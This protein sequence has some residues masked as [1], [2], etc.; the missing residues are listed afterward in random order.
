MTEKVMKMM[1]G[2]ILSWV[3]KHLALVSGTSDSGEEKTLVRQALWPQWASRPGRRQNKK[4]R[5]SQEETVEKRGI[6]SAQNKGW[7]AG[8]VTKATGMANF[9]CPLDWP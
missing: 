1:T 3:Q 2:W 5:T 7:K 9:M 6:G 4:M 8:V